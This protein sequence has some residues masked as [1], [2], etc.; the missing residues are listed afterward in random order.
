MINTRKTQKSCNFEFHHKDYE[1]LLNGT[2]SGFTNLF[3]R[4]YYPQ[5]GIKIVSGPQ[6]TVTD[7]QRVA[8]MLKILRIKEEG[9]LDEEEN[10][11]L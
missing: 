7:R 1:D 8:Q 3:D 6:K 11:C 10:P 5:N 9:E 2:S 4:I